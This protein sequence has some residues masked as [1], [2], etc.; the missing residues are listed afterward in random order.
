VRHLR[1]HHV[2]DARMVKWGTRSGVY[3]NSTAAI[4]HVRVELL[5]RRTC[6]VV[7]LD[8]STKKSSI[9]RFWI[10]KCNDS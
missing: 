3:T 1:E 8:R 9:C 5:A 7:W 4:T 6:A 10:L 2:G